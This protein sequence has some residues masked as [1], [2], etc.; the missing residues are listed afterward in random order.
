MII[1]HQDI[2][3]AIH[4]GSGIGQGHRHISSVIRLYD[5]ST[6]EKEVGT[7]LSSYIQTKGEKKD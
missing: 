3:E 6:I 4:A 1:G 5:S 2:I 7:Q